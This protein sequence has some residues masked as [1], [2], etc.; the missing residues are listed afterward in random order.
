MGASRTVSG[1]KLPLRLSLT[2][3]LP[4]GGTAATHLFGVGLQRAVDFDAVVLTQHRIRLNQLA[5]NAQLGGF[6]VKVKVS[7]D[8]ENYLM[9][10]QIVQAQKGEH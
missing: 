4:L 1:G 9:P 5:K 7:Q 6:K 10:W 3:P 8:I 2:Q